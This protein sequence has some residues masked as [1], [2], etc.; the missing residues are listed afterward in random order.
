MAKEEPLDGCQS[1]KQI[2]LVA[3]LTA[4]DLRLAQ[5]MR[6]FAWLLTF[7]EFFHLPCSMFDDVAAGAHGL[8]RERPVMRRCLQMFDFGL[9][10]LPLLF[11]Q[12]GRVAP[13]LRLLFNDQFGWPLIVP[14]AFSSHHPI[15]LFVVS[16]LLLPP[17]PSP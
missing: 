17:P 2:N 8:K 9:L 14:T 13:T 10:L 5:A 16:L 4:A 3:T 1:G 15:P 7:F 12:C 6:R 11:G